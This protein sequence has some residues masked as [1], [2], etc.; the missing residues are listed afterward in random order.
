MR[1]AHKEETDKEGQKEALAEVR[2]HRKGVEGEH[3]EEI[4]EGFLKE[5]MLEPIAHQVCE[6]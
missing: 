1:P 6:Q 2:T 4:K 3:I 5:V